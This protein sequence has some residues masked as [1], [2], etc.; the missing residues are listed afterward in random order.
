MLVLGLNNSCFNFGVSSLKL[1]FFISRVQRLGNLS[2][3]LETMQRE[4]ARTAGIEPID[5]LDG[6]LEK[7]VQL[8]WNIVLRSDL[9]YPGRGCEIFKGFEYL[10]CLPHT[11]NM[12]QNLEIFLRI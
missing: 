8:I 1:N 10:R 7:T 12:P 4:R 6:N 5:I 11:Q 3:A 9:K 2:S